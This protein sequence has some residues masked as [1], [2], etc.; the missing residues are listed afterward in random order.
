MKTYAYRFT[1]MLFA[2][3]TCLLVDANHLA[4][5][6]NTAEVDAKTQAIGRESPWPLSI[7]SGS[8][9]LTVFQPQIDSWDGYHLNARLAVR[10]TSA[11]NPPQNSYGVITVQATTLTDK[12][13]R[14]VTINQATIVKSD[15]RSVPAAQSQAWSSAIAQDF[16]GKSRTIALDRLQQQLAISHAQEKIEGKPLRNVAPEF[17]FSTTPSMQIY[18]DGAPTYRAMSGLPYERVI[19]TRALVLRD[20]SNTY[21]LKL[22]DGWMSASAL[23]GPWRVLTNA[24]ANLNT[25]FKQASDAHLIDPL[26]GQSAPDKPG[27]S[28]KTI[29]PTI[30]V[31]TKP[32]ELIV[33]NGAP[34]Y[35]AVAGTHLEY[36]ENTTGHVFKHLPDNQIYVLVSG[37]WFRAADNHGPWEYVAA[38][39]LPADFAQ[40][41]DDSP[42]ENVKA[43]IAGTQQA[44]DAV[45]ETSV[46]QTAAVNIAG[47]TLTPPKF[48][49]TPAFQAIPETALEYVANTSTPIVRVGGSTVYAM[50][51]GVWFTA[52]SLNG[53]WTV[54]TSVPAEIYAIPPSSS[55]YYLTFVR[56]YEVSGNTVYVGYTPGY[57]GAYI[58][59]TTGVVVYGTGY[60]YSPWVGAVWYGDSVTYGY[61]AAIA[62]TPWSGWAY[63]FGFGW[64]WGAATLAYGWGWGPYP[65]WGPWAYPAW[66]GGVAWGAAGGA[67]AWGPGG[68]AGYSGNI[69]QQWGNRASVSR[70]AGGFDAWTGNRWAGQ[71][72]ASYNSRTGIASAGQR[73]GVANV[74]SGNYAGGAR[75]VATG[76]AG[77]VVVGSH[78]TAGNAYSGNQVSGNRGAV[79]NKS[80]GQWTNV[81]GVSGPNGGH[82]GHVGDDVYAGKDGN[83]YRNTGNGWQQHT[84]G[85][86]QPVAGSAQGQATRN[87]TGGLGAQRANPQGM[88]PSGAGADRI[89]EL[90]QERSGRFNGG[91]QA[92]QLRQSSMGMSRGHFGRR[93]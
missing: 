85:G 35:V 91:M 37:R 42:V 2:L 88:A 10:A 61:A 59:P 76:P 41:P 39:A 46:P 27:P 65:Y 80:T 32:T 82:A 26:T 50:Q 22:F 38:N 25:A 86:W 36:V 6:A 67:V 43:S 74:Y 79:Y 29:V 12:G 7:T 51:N 4:N 1:V 8:T 89:G 3:T 47:T 92:N 54:A 13:T 30:F 69:Y 49:G 73:G 77:N 55:L 19:N 33:T 16:A 45:I 93:R 14:V 81:G 90:N 71:V 44:T 68:W 56:I 24:P 21:Y 57:Q 58:D 53:N 78:G 83:V 20:S 40:I 28:L 11:T 5:A 84:D 70:V 87:A 64:Y 23:E 52:P 66:Y 34:K 9:K 62:Y 60:A 75:G 18:V 15:F 63:G 17:I 72:G 31:V 48:D